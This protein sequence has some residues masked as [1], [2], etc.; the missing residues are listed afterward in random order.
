MRHFIEILNNNRFSNLRFTTVDCLN[1]ADGLTADEVE[2]LLV[3]KEKIWIKVLDN[4]ML[5]IV[6]MT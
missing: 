6:S 2:D 3:E 5:K 1:N 4:I